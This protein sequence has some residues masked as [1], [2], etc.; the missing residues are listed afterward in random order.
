MIKKNCSQDYF[1][2]TSKEI[3]KNL[4]ALSFS[5]IQF[6][7]QDEIQ[8]QRTG[9]TAPWGTRDSHIQLFTAQNL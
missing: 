9:G 8:K 7:K 5:E 4:E 2:Y 6:F 1:S 3:Q